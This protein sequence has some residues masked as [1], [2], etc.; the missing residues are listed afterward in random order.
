MMKKKLIEVALP[1]EA[2]NEASAREKS[3]RHGHPSTLHLWWARRPL[4]AAR[5]VIFSSLVDDPS[6]HPDQFPTEEAQEKER[7]RL[8][9]I[10]ERLVVW[11]NSNDEKLLA[12][13]KA[14]IARSTDGNIPE[15]LDPF[16]GGGAIP[17]EAQRLGLKAHASDLNPVAVMIN[18]AM[19]EIPPKFQGLPPV[20]PEARAKLGSELAWKGLTGLAEDVRYYG[21]WMKEEAFKRIG[22]LYPKAKLP[23][24]SEATVIAWI[25]ARTV[26]CP[27]PACGCEMPLV[28]S[29]WLSKRKG[30]EAYVLPMI[31]NGKITFKVHQ[32][33]PDSS[34]AKLLDAGTG[35]INSR[36]KRVKAT[37]ICS[38]CKSG[39]AKGEYIDQEANEERMHMI[40]IAIV[41]ENVGGRLYLDPNNEQSKKIDEFFKSNSF[42]E[43][44]PNEK[45]K[46]TFAS[47]AMGRPYGF[48]FF[49]DYFTKRQ[50]ISLVTFSELVAELQQKVFEDAISIGM[51]EDSISLDAAGSGAKAYGEAI[52]VYLAMLVD[53]LADLGNSLNRWEPNAQCPR[54]LFA[55]QAIPIVWDFA[56]GNP[57]SDSSGSWEVLLGNL[58]RSFMAPAFCFSRDSHG[59]ALQADATQDNGLRSIMISTDP[60]YYNNIGYADLSDFFYVWMRRSLRY[61]YPNLFSTMLVPKVEELIATPYRFDGSKEKARDFF[62]D[63]M[64]RTFSQVHKYTREDIP[65]T[66]YYAFKQSETNTEDENDTDV[67]TVVTASTGWET[68]L[69]AVIQA[70]FAITGTW[71]IRTEMSSRAVAQGANALASS[72]VLVCRKRHP[73]ASFVTR[74]D[75]LA[76]LRRELKPA[77]VQLQHANIA[78][79]D[80]AQSAIGPGM[81]V[82][83]R[84]GKVLDADG[85]P[86]SVR[87]ALQIINQLVDEFF[88]EQEGDLDSESRFCVELF[89]QVAFNPIK[90][91]TAEVLATAKSISISKLAQ[92]GVLNSSKGS[93]QLTCRD[94]LQEFSVMNS[95]IT[96][97]VTQQ[98]T[99]AFEKHG[100][101]GATKILARVSGT[102][103]ENA[104][105]LAYRLYTIAERKGWATEAYAYNV[106]VS[107]WMDIQQGATNQ[108]KYKEG[109]LQFE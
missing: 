33:T 78:P 51:A 102:M 20:N 103:A 41:A 104:K 84:N 52:S 81:A 107:S 13:V 56:E 74:K 105:A 40:P 9:N 96:W 68:M 98:I 101:D 37:F 64:L 15:F 16:A 34:T 99:K 35:Y 72:I 87:S 8:F 45:C 24:G 26:K 65:V 7:Q 63:G 86:M 92:A 42:Q 50:L 30:K 82:Y 44:I 43:R 59:A 91:G 57:F 32:N 76:T 94:D 49:S 19:I 88:N 75:F 90:Y 6:S 48:K 109:E 3:I 23:N 11:E 67:T 55:R 79:V 39:V 93:V 61:T 60:P 38:C 80:L 70:G 21:E 14:E 17:L 83:S 85:T 12:E 1:L 77:L 58:V 66:I 31:Y 69:S 89:S 2:I 10:L 62:E 73:S 18:K 97:L 54:Q 4:A 47:N 29:F 95:N 25:W 108:V 71:P 22:H 46:G 27:N 106:L 100:I 53:K 5:A 36:G 28:N